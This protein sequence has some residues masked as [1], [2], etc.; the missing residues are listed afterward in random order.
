[1]RTK[2]YNELNI[3]LFQLKNSFRTGLFHPDDIKTVGLAASTA[4]GSAPVQN[5]SRK[6]SRSGFNTVNGSTRR[7]NGSSG[8]S[9]GQADAK[10]IQSDL[11]KFDK[12]AETDDDDNYEDVF[13]KP[14]GTSGCRSS[15]YLCLEN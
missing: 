4:L 11:D 12:Y 13:G 1:M 7:S 2:A 14:S 8:G 3:L 9:T 5:L 6:S 10:R 15:L